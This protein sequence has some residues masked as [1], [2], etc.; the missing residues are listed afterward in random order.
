MSRV[1][2]VGD[3]HFPAIHPEYLSFVKSIK[4][5]WKTNHTVFIGDIVDSQAIS[6]H[7]KHPE[8][9][10]AVEEH[11]QTMKHL[12]VWYKAFKDAVVCIGNHDERVHRM[13]A[14]K[15]IPQMYLREYSDVY[16]T[17]N[18]DWDY[19]HEIDN[20]LYTH[21]TGTSGLNPSFNSAKSRLQS[22]V[23]GHHHSVATISWIAGPTTRLFGMCVGSGVDKNHNSVLNHI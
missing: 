16:N 8:L 2:V 18:W 23:Q 20:I 22:C 6:F 5:K 1:L 21:G 10:S 4:K 13:A 19:Q 9:P 3:L 12:S 14:D 7:A 15:G 17:P 11:E